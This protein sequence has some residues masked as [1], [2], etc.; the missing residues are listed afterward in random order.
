MLVRVKGDDESSFENAEHVQNIIFVF[1]H[2][3]KL[4]PKVLKP[5]S[6]HFMHFSQAIVIR[7]LMLNLC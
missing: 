4:T 3:L 6:W 7:I 2:R 5:S 1:L